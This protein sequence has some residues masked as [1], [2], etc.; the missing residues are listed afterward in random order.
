MTTRR[1][2]SEEAEFYNDQLMDPFAEGG[3]RYAAEG[4]FVE[5]DRKGQKAVC[6]WFKKGHVHESKFFDLDI[7]AMEKSV[8]LVKSW[9]DKRIIE[10]R[11][12]VN[13]PEVWTFEKSDFFHE[14]TKVL[15][16][17][18]IENY[19]KFNSNTGWHDSSTPWPKV[20]QALSHFT[21]HASNGDYLL[22]DLQGGVDSKGVVLTDP[23]ILSKN[24]EFGLTDLG[25]KGISSFFSQHKCN[26]FCRSH[27]R[28]P[29]N[30]A[31]YFS[32]Q[33]G[34][35]MSSFATMPPPPPQ[36]VF[37]SSFN[38]SDSV[39]T[40]S[41][42]PTMAPPPPRQLSCSST[43]SSISALVPRNLFPMMPPPPKRS[44]PSKNF[45]RVGYLRNVNLFGSLPSVEE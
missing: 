8:E 39:S 2:K 41:G 7:K 21:Y 12:R 28:K 44:K 10:Q 16:E 22:C 1:N 5:G 20:M 30:R 45:S 11:I 35:S 32:P 14:D 23:A 37:R 25:S 29:N 31:Q 15:V 3:F 24:S 13:V 18:F 43:E 34:T 38:N 19:K 40:A 9:S 4:E 36:F 17:P 42:F 27:W 33:E 26:E 6:K